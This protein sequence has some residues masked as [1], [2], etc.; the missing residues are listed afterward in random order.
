M[1]QVN[2]FWEGGVRAIRTF[3]LRLLLDP[4]DPDVLKGALQLM[5]EGQPQPFSDEQALLSLLHQQ[6]CGLA[7]ADSTGTKKHP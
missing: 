2:C 3:I 6:V 1:I 4:A 5:P 7:E